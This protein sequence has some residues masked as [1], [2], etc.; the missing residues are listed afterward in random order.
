[1]VKLT[2]GALV[3]YALSVPPLALFFEFNPTSIS[4]SRSITV[5]TGGSR[6][7]RGGYDF[8]TPTETPRASQGVTVNAESFTVKVL[9]DATDRMN[10]PSHIGHPVVMEF[11]VQ[12]EL[13]TIRTM[14]EPKSQSPGGVQTL[15]ALGQ[16]SE[17]AFARDESA[18]VLLFVWGQHIL[19]VFL[20][21]AQIEEKAYLPSLAPYRAEAT[22]TL[23]VIESNNPFNKVELARQVVS[24]AMNT[25]L[26]TASALGSLF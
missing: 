17:R 3:E 20:T 1:M 22:L 25:G 7:T 5:R 4:R 24:A 6:A 9:F 14:V 18:S 8:S 13:D 26:T 23:Q 16:G 11:G 21:Q 2:Q 15:S 10:D 12:P 19:P